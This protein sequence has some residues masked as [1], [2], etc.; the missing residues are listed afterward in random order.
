MAPPLGLITYSGIA[1]P[2]FGQVV[3]TV[4]P[5]PDTI[6]LYCAPQPTPP[7]LVGS[8]TISYG[9]MTRVLSNCRVQTVERLQNAQG[10]VWRLTLLDRRWVWQTHGRISGYYNVRQGDGIDPETERSPRELAELCLEAMGEPYNLRWLKSIPDD[11]RPEVSWDVA[12]PAVAL[13]ELL[14]RLDCRILLGE[15]DDLQIWRLNDGAT[16]PLVDFMSG[17]LSSVVPELYRSLDIVGDRD[18]WQHDFDLE[19]VGQDLD[20][21][22]KPID[23]LSYA[24]RYR[25]RGQLI[26]SWQQAT[27]NMNIVRNSKARELAIATV[28]RWYRIKAPIRLPGGTAA[29]HR[30]QVLPLLTEQLETDADEQGRRQPRPAILFGKF[31]SFGETQLDQ[32]NGD[33]NVVQ[34][35]L[36][37]YDRTFSI[38]R[39]RGIVMLNEP[40]WRKTQQREGY[41][42]APAELK[43]RT[44]CNLRDEETRA[45]QRTIITKRPEKPGPRGVVKSLLREDVRRERYYRYEMGKRKFVDTRADAAAVGKY[46]WEVEQARSKVLD[47]GFAERPGFIGLAPNGIIRQVV[48]SRASGGQP[49]T[50]LAFNSEVLQ[51]VMSYGERRF[52]WRLA[53][54]RQES[55]DQ[56]RRRREVDRG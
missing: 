17:G 43:L 36:S 14:D 39:E 50:S 53:Q 16:G 1:A 31:D 34:F 22:I 4:G 52:Y 3:Q 49:T 44:S 37:R 12:L 33:P 23:R 19:A 38:D 26:T 20:G 2:M 15:R 51:D 56:E 41:L 42:V 45:W 48:W 40:L 8:V 55:A 25:W 13:A 29:R 24:P 10:P 7:Q 46:Y 35:P 27:E 28:F 54:Q 6:S 32:A 9:R 30:W 47:A 21:S 11:T 5:I 18:V